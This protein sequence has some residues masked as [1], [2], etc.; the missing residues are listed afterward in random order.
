MDME[1]WREKFKIT[2]HFHQLTA[3]QSQSEVVVQML[4]RVIGAG[5]GKTVSESIQPNA[6][7]S[8]QSKAAR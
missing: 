3:N 6:K 7:A 2:A 8:E 1:K 4:R 5:E